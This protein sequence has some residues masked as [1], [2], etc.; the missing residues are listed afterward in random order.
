[1][2]T[3]S[4]L[5]IKGQLLFLA[6]L[7]LGLVLVTT[8]VTLKM[9]YELT[10]VEKRSEAQHL[11]ESARTAIE[12]YVEAAR[13][14]A[15]SPAEAQAKALA[16]LKVMRYDGKNYFFVYRDDG[17]AMLLPVAKDVGTNRLNVTDIHNFEFVKA[18]I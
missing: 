10:F 12:P 4:R 1:M 11:V 5:S 15:M 6:S 14:G 13:T 8:G 16:V 2:A 17:V 3:I 18:F 7:C 9:T